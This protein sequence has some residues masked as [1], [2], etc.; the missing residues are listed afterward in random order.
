MHFIMLRGG[1]V[2]VFL[3]LLM[4][5]MLIVIKWH[6]VSSKNGRLGVLSDELEYNYFKSGW[7]NERNIKNIKCF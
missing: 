6:F 1:L 2:G 5:E 3:S 4:L 7:I